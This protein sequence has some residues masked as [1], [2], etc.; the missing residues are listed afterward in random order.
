MGTSSHRRQILLFLLAVILPCLILVAVTL[1]MLLQEHELAE[2]RRAEDRNRAAREIGRQLMIELER[3]R[4]DL[5]RSE[6][7]R[8]DGRSGPQP[9]GAAVVATAR[10]HDNQLLFP[11]DSYGR[12][13]SEQSSPAL[14]SFSGQL[15]QGEI[16]E[17]T[18]KRFLQAAEYYRSALGQAQDGAQR[19]VARLLLARVLTKAGQT[20]EADDHYRQLLEISPDLCDEQGVPFCIYAAS[21]LLRQKNEGKKAMDTLQTV[22]EGNRPLTPTGLY[23]LRAT[24]KEAFSAAGETALREQAATLVRTADARIPVLEQ[25][26]ALQRDFPR[27]MQDVRAIAGKGLRA[28]FWLPYGKEPWLLSIETRSGEEDPWA[29]IVRPQALFKSIMQESGAGRE[30]G[31]PVLFADP[32]QEG[33]I[34]STQLPGLKLAFT[35]SGEAEGN[36]QFSLRSAFFLAALL[37]VVSLTLFGSYLLWRDMRRELRMA[38]MRSQFVASVSH[39]LKTPLTAIRMFAETLGMGRPADEQSQK[40]YLNTIVSESD[41]LRRLI[42]NVLDFS[43]IEQGSRTYNREPVQLAEIVHAA[44]SSM[45]HPLTKQGFEL[46]VDVQ[47]DLPEAEV[48]ADAIEQAILNLLANAM[49]YSGKSRHI[50][51][52]LLKANDEILIQVR[53]RGVGIP[54]KEQ[55]RIFERFYRASIPENQSIPGT[56]LG[57]ALVDH[58]ARGHGGRV[59]V[60]SEPGRGSTFTIHLPLEAT[61]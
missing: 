8:T 15:E 11:W 31:N 13:P 29:M 24:A 7:F 22:L 9:A 57:L 32:L 23:M 30:S 37:L 14:S 6:T 18:E 33:E 38:E 45:Q 4:L 54:E 17:F 10:I 36:A 56:G 3:I 27:L 41:R 43:R 16:L 46:Q 50:D 1:R 35:P 49:K 53:D 21:R 28:P 40:D 12:G 34:L 5:I 55:E 42:D 58:I 39:E 26:L 59:E 48:D 47:E 25:V 19:C 52:R 2:K 61:P 51:L 20:R 60:E 44:A